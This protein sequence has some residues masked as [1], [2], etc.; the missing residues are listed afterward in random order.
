MTK[1]TTNTKN[2]TTALDRFATAEQAQAQLVALG[3]LHAAIAPLANQYRQL[4]EAFERI[5]ALEA[6]QIELNAAMPALLAR[7]RQ[8]VIDSLTV[9]SVR[10]ADDTALSALIVEYEFGFDHATGKPHTRKEQLHAAG[11]ELHAAVAQ[12][13]HLL[14]ASVLEFGDGDAAAGIEKYLQHKRRG[15]IAGPSPTVYGA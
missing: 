6:E 11:R 14:P 5:E 13:A 8:A 2:T 3:N 1:N 15:Y 9:V 4:K 10:A 12:A 7:D